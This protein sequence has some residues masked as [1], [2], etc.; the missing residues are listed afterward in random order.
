MS[1]GTH[2]QYVEDPGAHSCGHRDV[3]PDLNPNG[4]IE[5]QE[6]VKPCLRFGM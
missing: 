6:W 2:K 1:S 4:M 3:S 5:S